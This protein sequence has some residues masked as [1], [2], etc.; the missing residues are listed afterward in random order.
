[1]TQVQFA[2]VMGA[3]PSAAKGAHLPVEMVSWDEAVEFCRRLSEKERRNYRLPTEAEW[4]YACRAGSTTAYS[5]GDDPAALDQYAWYANNSGNSVLDAIQLWK[6][7]PENYNRRLAAN[8][9]Q[10]HPVGN[11]PPNAWGLHDMHGNVYEWCQ[12]WFGQDWFDPRYGSGPLREDPTG[13]A[14]GSQ[15]VLRGGSW[16]HDARDCRS[17]VR[18]RYWPNNRLS[19]LGFRVVLVRA[20]K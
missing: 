15:R 18:Y 14:K 8:G 16:M 1:M 10:T 11:K 9:C 7:G 6:T 20:G 4:E 3:N 2:Q 5:F 13:P 12:D 17:A 19:H